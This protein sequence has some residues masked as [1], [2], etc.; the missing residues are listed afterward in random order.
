MLLS[1]QQFSENTGITLVAEGVEKPEELASLTDAGVRC[2]QGYIFARPQ[3]TL[4][5]PDWSALQ[6]VKR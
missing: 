4:T 1:I 5:E 3:S 6:T 2:A